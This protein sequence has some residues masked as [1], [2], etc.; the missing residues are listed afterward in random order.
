MTR[1]A[2]NPARTDQGAMK[3]PYDSI[4]TCDFVGILSLLQTGAGSQSPLATAPEATGW[5]HA[6]ITASAPLSHCQEG[7]LSSCTG[8][9]AC[10]FQKQD[11]RISSVIRQPPTTHGKRMPSFECTAI[12]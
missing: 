9:V 4:G 12:I 7:F 10:L 5:Q 6:A 11:E 3:V 2:E 8:N 1:I